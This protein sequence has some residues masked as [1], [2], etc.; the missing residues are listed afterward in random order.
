MSSGG[1]LVP[2]EAG[3]WREAWTPRVQAEW[4]REVVKLALSKPYVENVAWASLADRDACVV[5]GC[6]LLDDSLQ[7]KPSFEAMNE[8]RAR[9]RPN[10]RPAKA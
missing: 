8:L 5:P 7:P 9:L 3:R 2:A 1:R 4:L 6:G 10:V